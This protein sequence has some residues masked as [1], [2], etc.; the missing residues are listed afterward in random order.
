MFSIPKTCYNI[1]VTL[2]IL[3]RQ[4]VQYHLKYILCCV[5]QNLNF[6]N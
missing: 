3:E 6:Y 5:N 2:I 1:V 4:K